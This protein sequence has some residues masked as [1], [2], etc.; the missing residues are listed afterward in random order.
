MQDKAKDKRMFA[1]FQKEYTII[2]SVK[3][4]PEKTYDMTRLLDISKGGLKFF[5]YEFFPIGTTIV[6]HIKFPFLYPQVTNIEGQVVAV[7]DVMKGKTYKISLNFIN[8][9]P[10]A[11]N[12][13]E[14]M[15]QLNLKK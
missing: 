13:L 7:Q 11:L 2:F 8:E 4:K 14:K 15:Q 5:S 3:N 1:R 9:T 12:A 6:F 10:E